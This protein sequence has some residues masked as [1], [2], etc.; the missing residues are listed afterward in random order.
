MLYLLGRAAF[1]HPFRTLVA[2][3]SAL[4]V[5]GTLAWLL[6]GSFDERFTVPGTE[7]QTALDQL[8]VT[9][10][11]ISSASAQM[12]VV[13][14]AATTV[15]DQSLM[16]AVTAQI[17]DLRRIPGVD[18]VVSPYDSPV[19]NTISADG[20]AAL[21]AIRLTGTDSEVTNA[22]RTALAAQATA[23][24][25]RL[26]G[27]VASA[28]GQ[29]LSVQRPGAS[30]VESLGLVVAIV[31]LLIT[32]GS[33]RAAGMP[34]LTAL[35]GVA[36]SMGLIYGATGVATVSST[37]PLL[38]L[39][40]GLT[41]GIDYALF[42]LS[43]HRDQL[44]H[45]MEPEESAAQAV[46]TAGSAVVFA[47]LTVVIALAGLAVARI[48]FLTT[49][50]L[51][52]ALAVAIAVGI[53]L[54][55]LP[56]LMGLAGAKMRPR[57]RP[58]ETP[59]T[60]Y[61]DHPDH[62][63]GDTIELLAI[64]APA[65]ASAPA[66]DSE[67]VLQIPPADLE[68]GWA[69]RWVRT[70]T[71]WPI[72]TIFVVL[73]VIG[74][75]ALPARDLRL[76][77]PDAGS[78]PLGS[79]ARTTY[80]L[81]STHF[82]PGF[83]GPLIVS[84][85]II[86]TDDP[87]KVVRDLA[88]EIRTVPG[89]AAVPLATPNAGAD[90]G[91]IQVVP[92]TAPDS[93]QTKDLVD[94]LR[95]LAPGWQAR[96]GVPTAVTGFTAA[97]I[98]VSDRLGG[99]LVPFGILV[100]GLSLLLL[101]MVFRSITVPIKATLGYLLSVV[102]AF[103]ATAL[104]FEHGWLAGLVNID[105]TGPVI[106]FLPIIL[107]GV[108]FEVFLVSR[109]RQDYVRGGSAQ[110]AVRTGFVGSA[111]VVVAAGVIMFSVFVF[112]VPEGDGAIK[113][114]AFGLAVGVFV[115]AFIV[116]M[117]LVPAVMA[118][119][120]RTA[121]WLPRRLDAVLPSFDIEGSSLHRQLRYADWPAP[122]DHHVLFAEDVA[123]AAGRRGRVLAG[124]VDIALVPRQVMVVTGDLASRTGVLLALTGRA[125]TTSGRI[126]VDGLLLPDRAGAVRARTAVLD[127]SICLDLDA[128]LRRLL[129][130]DP[131]VLVIDRLDGLDAAG[132]A[133][134]VAAVAAVTASDRRCAV[135]LGV[136]EAAHAAD[137]APPGSRVLA[138]T[139]ADVPALDAPA[140]TA[141]EGTR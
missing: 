60:L 124:P 20:S 43:R 44:V 125:A 21:I 106:S 82:G 46:A 93:E 137:L 26:P 64:E 132:R 98:D 30:P 101:M 14:P 83:N 58:V 42:I 27:L 11:E 135:L 49:M 12:V 74:A 15:R 52:A 80:D 62:P 76:A 126:K 37:T 50:G 96:Y 35:L 141:D 112:F 17:V 99:A 1:R 66:D 55:L 87:L 53:A 70:S 8:A 19:A 57:Q 22:T 100:V 122:T 61:S 2:W 78:Q 116:R 28:G 136:T 102:A 91:I 51:A 75:L 45:G 139:S 63:D 18:S 127:A 65:G 40:L 133:V 56:A 108:L 16:D 34:I 123:V 110:L 85:Q 130:R 119:L 33:L 113:T 88:A 54:T 111:K 5:V 23:L 9:F 95:A 129:R 117:T 47:G 29:A 140:I 86:G 128:E 94:R 97:G 72:V 38:A 134:V 107:M 81:I 115:D 92:T 3:L 10:A 121:W 4:A 48:P 6:A 114:I 90:T 73:L 39:M 7:S 131:A 25:R 89:V 138:V 103:G 68:H 105:H 104:V 36:I 109:M 120:G 67:D 84:A 118:L 71:R 41:V 32:L 59:P 77:L 31:V 69:A 79:P 24:E 13:A